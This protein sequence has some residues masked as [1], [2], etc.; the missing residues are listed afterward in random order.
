MEIV[1]GSPELLPAM[2]AGGGL[3]VLVF[4]AKDPSGFVG[5][6]ELTFFCSIGVTGVK[7]C[8]DFSF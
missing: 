7:A 4:V 1:L 3:T 2:L 6:L 8:L 5:M